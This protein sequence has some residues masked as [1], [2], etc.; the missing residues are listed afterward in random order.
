MKKALV[1]LLI[2]AIILSS[3][4]A[5]SDKKSVSFFAYDTTVSLTFYGKRV[6]DAFLN[7][8]IDYIKSFETHFSMTDED[9][10]LYKLN[11]ERSMEVSDTLLECIK[12][13]LSYCELT[14]GAF[15][16]TLGTVNRLWNVT[17]RKLPPTQA[18]IDEARQNT[19]H[20][21]IEITDN[22]VTIQK[23][24]LKIDL[25]GFAKGY[26]ADKF[27]EYLKEKG[28]D[29][30]VLLVMGGAVTCIGRK[31]ATEENFKVGIVNPYDKSNLLTT[32]DI[33]NSNVSTSGTS[34]R[35]FEY[36]GV[37]Y[38]H[39]MNPHTGAPV[40]NDIEQV[41]VICYDAA[42]GDALSTAFFVMGLNNARALIEN[43]L[44]GV[45]AVFAMKN[46]E[47]IY[48]NYVVD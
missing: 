16:I 42:M 20:E 32:L 38:H 3:A 6:K 46:G 9:S 36:E 27:R 45:G 14:N 48:V 18:E 5:N 34:E 12:S 8:C 40:Q 25:S 39:I 4:C 24:G 26:V 1:F 28:I 13:A 7:E 33:S 30:G 15:D 21:Y 35:Y 29:S 41:T 44:E 37:R 17:E 2:A 22:R 19:G 10:E 43:E 11:K 23:E 47:I 31:S